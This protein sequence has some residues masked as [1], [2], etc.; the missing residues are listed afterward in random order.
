MRWFG[1]RIYSPIGL[2]LGA[3][4]FKAVQ[5][6]RA[7]Q[8]WTVSS[9][10]S[11]T[12]STPGAP[13]AAAEMHRLQGVLERRGFVGSDVVVGIPRASLLTANLELPARAPGVPLEQIATIEFARVH[14][15]DAAVLTVST[16]ELPAP[17]RAGKATYMLAVGAP[18]QTLEA[19]IDVVECHGLNVVAIE[20]PF[21]AAVRGVM[22]AAAPLA[23]L[24]AVI[25]LGWD[26]TALT[27]VKDSTVVYTRML[28]DSGLSRLHASALEAADGDADVVDEHLW[29]V[30]F[31]DAGRTGQN[32]LDV[33]DALGAF[34]DGVT[35]EI[36]QAFSYT[37]HRYH[38]MAV[39]RGTL[40]GGGAAVPGLAKRFEEELGATFATG[41]M[42]TSAEPVEGS[43]AALVSAMGMALWPGEP[44]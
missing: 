16:W 9:S 2:D 42:P 25:D 30:G 44:R 27:M 12:R 17:A 1:K 19:F 13:L 37:S 20:E 35:R 5:L 22:Q 4:S 24:T 29:H 15:Q 41:Q 26:R 34:V 28:A 18:S 8:G 38:D 10:I 33:L 21:S 7:D 3:H 32:R 36:G 31:S 6:K 14:K 11:L 23:E 40:I 39:A 43:H